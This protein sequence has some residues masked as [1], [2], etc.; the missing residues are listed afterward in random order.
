[1][2]DGF[3]LVRWPRGIP[4]ND[5]WAGTVQ[6]KRDYILKQRKKELEYEGSSK[7]SSKDRHLHDV[8]LARFIVS[9][10]EKGPQTLWPWVS[11]Y[12]SDDGNLDEVNANAT[13]LARE[14]GEG[15]HRDSS[16]TG[17]L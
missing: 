14:A 8:R 17:D 4:S 9:H 7:N 10:P 2:V 3:F 6:A 16:A 13:Q 12:L 11:F 15:K 1:M 5:R